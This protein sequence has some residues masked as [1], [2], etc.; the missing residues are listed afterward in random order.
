MTGE[1][2]GFGFVE[3]FTP[4]D[5]ARA[6]Q[7]LQGSRLEGQEEPLAL[8]AARDLPEVGPAGAA[9]GSNGPPGAGPDLEEALAY[10]GW[11]PKAYGDLDEAA[12]PQAAQQQAQAAGGQPQPQPQQAAQVQ[13][14]QAAAMEAAAAAPPGFHYDP[15]SGYLKDPISGY[16]FDA[17]TRE[18]PLVA[19]FQAC[20]PALVWE[21]AF[22]SKMLLTNG[23]KPRQRTRL[24]GSEAR[25]PVPFCR[26]LLPPAA[27]GVGEL[28]PHHRPLH[29]L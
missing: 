25:R 3:F 11:E 12:Q 8:S 6:L 20:S 15:A 29:A 17:N 2:R 18:R 28:R 21:E 22:L 26:A 10:V 7:A 9:A 19:A 24:Q 1:P 4:E 14:Q 23:G 5:A 16:F 27:A 13:A